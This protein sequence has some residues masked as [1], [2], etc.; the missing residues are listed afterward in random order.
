MHPFLFAV[1]LAAPLAI[2]EA[3]PASPPAEPE[4]V[5][6]T[7]IRVVPLTYARAGELAHTLSLIFPHLRVIPYRPTNS[8]IIAGPRGAVEDLIGIIGPANRD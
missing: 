8:L 3:Q 2:A 7:T 1:I 4:P 5:E 6:A